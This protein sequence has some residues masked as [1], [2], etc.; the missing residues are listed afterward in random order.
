MKP[1]SVYIQKLNDSMTMHCCAEDKLTD[2]GRSLVS[3]TRK[4]GIPLPFQRHF[5]TGGNLTIQNIIP[6]DRGVYVCTA[7]NEAA[8]IEADAE[9][10]I[11][12]FSPKAPSNLTATSTKDSITIR[13][14]QNYVRADLKFSIWYRA[15]SL[16][17]TN[18]N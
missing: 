8:T 7:A 3:W 16:T 9:L 12:T 11:E 1:K 4:D 14:T 10:L 2:D 13:W 6:S 15:G 17:E 5:L 18:Q